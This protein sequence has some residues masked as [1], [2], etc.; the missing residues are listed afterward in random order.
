MCPKQSL[1]K[2]F[3]T[4]KCKNG[5]PSTIPNHPMM[6]NIAQSE[7]PLLTCLSLIKIPGFRRRFERKD[8]GG[9]AIK[10]EVIGEEVHVVS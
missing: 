8:L 1:N 4:G 7:L 2:K 5:A 3:S 6:L 10:A 9:E